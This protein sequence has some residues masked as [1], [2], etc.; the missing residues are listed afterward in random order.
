[1]SNGPHTLLLGSWLIISKT[2]IEKNFLSADWYY[3][4]SML[5]LSWYSYCHIVLNNCDWIFQG[6]VQSSKYCWI[7]CLI[8]DGSVITLLGSLIL[9]NLTESLCWLSILL[10]IDVELFW[11]LVHLLAM[12]LLICSLI[13]L[14]FSRFLAW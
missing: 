8:S 13:F 3:K 11:S 6:A 2:S 4:E 5:G 10:I 9:S 7:C 1:M 14:I 12:L